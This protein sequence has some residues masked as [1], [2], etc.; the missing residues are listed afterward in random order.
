MNSSTLFSLNLMF[1]SIFLLYACHDANLSVHSTSIGNK[2]EAFGVGTNHFRFSWKLESNVRN[3]SQTAYQIVVASDRK[4]L[5]GNYPIWDSGKTGS[6]Q[7]ILVN[8]AGPA[9]EPGQCYF[10]KVK[11][12]DNHGNESEWSPSIPFIT[13]LETEADW[14]DARWIGYEELPDSMRLVEGVTGYGNLS[15]DKVE[16]RAVLPQFRKEFTLKDKI[17][18][19]T[20]FISGIGQY[21]ASINGQK[22]GDD[23]LSP[24]W[25]HFDKTILYNT[26]DVTSMLK[27]GENAIGVLVG[28]GFYYNNRERYR[29]LIIAYGFPKMICKLH[30]RYKNGESETLVS[31]KLWQMKPSPITYSSIYGG[32]DYDARL[33]ES[34]WNLPGFNSNS[35]L[36]ALEVK[37]PAGILKP[38]ENHPVKVMETFEPVSITK[39]N[40]TVFVYDFGQNASGIVSLNIKGENGQTVQLFP[41]EVINQEGFVNQRGSG[42]PYYF[43]YTLKGGGEE[44][45]N[46]RFTYYGFRYVQLIGA[47]P[48]TARNGKGL[49]VVLKLKSLHTRNATPQVGNFECSNELFNRTFNLIN[50][51]IKSNIQS[52]MTDCPTREKLGWLEQTH[53]VGPSIHYNFC[54]YNLYQKLIGDM[55]DAMTEKGLVPSIVPEYINFEYYDSD[56]RDSP[57]WGSALL[58]QP[59][60]LYKWYGDFSIL[61][62]SWPEM[63]QYFSYLEKKSSGNLLS[64]GLGDWYDVGP[65]VPGYAQLTP[66]PLVASAMYYY[67]AV[68]MSDIAKILGKSDDEKY[69][70]LLADEI[71]KAFN[72]KFYHPDT[73][74]YGSGSQTSMAM[75]LSMGL[76]PEEDVPLVFN[77][78]LRTIQSD[79]NQITA[80]DIGFHFLMDVLIQHGAAELLYAMNLRDDVPGYGYQLKKGA[81]SLTESWQALETKSMNHLMLGHLMEWFYSGL[82]GIGQTLNSVAYQEVLIAPQMI[83]GLD[84][85]SASFESPY[86]RILSD[87]RIRSGVFI[88]HVD[89]PVGSV[90]T[91]NLPRK[92]GQ[93]VLES[94]KPI[95]ERSEII[96]KKEADNSLSLLV[97]SGKYRFEVR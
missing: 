87:W 27:H 57:E 65:Q 70:R 2:A 88:H 83:G 56:F 61:E 39:L 58:L 9:L 59:W 4:S 69:F 66:V 76:V 54:M 33:E 93:S 53:L 90:A 20:L 86:G 80:G 16:K 22:V 97:G 36:Q 64:H 55:K 8:Y 18:S 51:G 68:L 44:Y 21:E 72:R 14:S 11:V 79:S 31:G 73:K 13:A 1:A 35:W 75:P 94:G 24:G 84:H 60:L 37:A 71:R 7:S 78:L 67:D 43:Q 40:D 50:W 26:Y 28:N 15:L 63:Q 6:R 82:A 96:I 30:I 52:V 85:A 42:S 25:T 92:M 23:F 95:A 10:W 45:W 91:I 38:E 89:I 62:T 41:G 48:D 47:V 3:T 19:A 81:T 49:P 46:P 77:N 12:W 32:E 29:K 74:I 34:G 5:N 17:E